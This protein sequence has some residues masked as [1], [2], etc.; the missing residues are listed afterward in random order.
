MVQ[1]FY[2]VRSANVNVAP[3][4]EESKG[5]EHTILDVLSESIV[6]QQLLDGLLHRF[7]SLK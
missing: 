2:V 7:D 3:T 4:R 1:E 6:L 5:I